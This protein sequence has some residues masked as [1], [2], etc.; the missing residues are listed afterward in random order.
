VT[1]LCPQILV[2]GIGNLFMGDDGFGVETARRLAL[3][4]LPTGVTVTDFGIRGLDLVYALLEPFEAVIFL[5][6]A[7][8]GGNPG[9]LYVIEPSLPSSVAA[10]V[11]AHGM[12]PVKVLAMARAMGAPPTRTL[13]VACEPAFLPPP[14][15]EEVVMELSPAVA[16]AVAEAIPLVEEWINRILANTPN[17]EGGEQE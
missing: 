5:D 12:D 8:R 4:P 10:S 9:T 13:I 14:D 3:R 15:S 2:A 11:D 16:T 17:V 7:Q 1:T 6:A